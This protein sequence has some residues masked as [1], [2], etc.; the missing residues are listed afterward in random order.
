MTCLYDATRDSPSQRVGAA[1]HARTDEG[2]QKSDNDFRLPIGA[3]RP[4]PETL[5]SCVAMKA[6][7]ARIRAEGLFDCPMTEYSR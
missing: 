1:A 4:L 3:R 5:R 6:F 2:R 7:Q